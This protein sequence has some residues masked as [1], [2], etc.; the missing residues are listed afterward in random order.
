MKLENRKC[1]MID[2]NSEEETPGAAKIWTGSDCLLGSVIQWVNDDDSL[3][4]LHNKKPCFFLG[5]KLGALSGF[6]VFNAENIVRT[7]TA[8]EA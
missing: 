6:K 8:I 2:Q 3:D 5:I 7:F 4:I 1:N